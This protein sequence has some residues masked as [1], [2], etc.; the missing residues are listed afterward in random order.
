M[1]EY[2]KIIHNRLR[3]PLFE[4]SG[5]SPVSLPLLIIMINVLYDEFYRKN[6]LNQFWSIWDI[7]DLSCW[8]IIKH[9]KKVCNTFDHNFKIFLYIIMSKVSLERN[10]FVLYDGVLTLKLSKMALNPFCD[11]TVHIKVRW[12]FNHMKGL[13][14]LLVGASWP[15]VL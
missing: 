2:L 13:E 11:K 10:Y 4:N 15:A 7:W 6:G 3:P 5:S 9:N 12:R 14:I 8:N 1:T